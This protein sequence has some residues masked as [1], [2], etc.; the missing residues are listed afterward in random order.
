MKH[1]APFL[2]VTL[3]LF[4]CS[5]QDSPLQ[6]LDQADP[7]PDRAI[8]D[9]TRA[10]GDPNFVWG[11]PIGYPHPSAYEQSDLSRLPILAVEVSEWDGWDWQILHRF[12]SAGDELK[13]E[14]HELEHIKILDPDTHPRYGVVWFARDDVELG[15]LYRITVHVGAAKLGYADVPVVDGFDVWEVDSEEFYGINNG[16]IVPIE[17]LVL[18]G[19]F[20]R[21]GDG[22][23]D[24]YDNCPYTPNPEQ[25]DADTDGDRL[26]D[27]VE[28][29]TGYFDNELITGTDPNNPD[30]DGDRL[31]DGD[32]IL[33]TLEGL[34]LPGFGVSPLVPSILIEYDWFE[35]DGHSHRPTAAALAKVTASFAAQ[36]IEVI[37]DYGQGPAPFTGGN[38]I[39]DEDGNVNWDNPPLPPYLPDE[40]TLHTRDNRDRNRRYWIRYVMLPHTINEVPNLAGL[41]L[42]PG[43]KF[44]V[45]TSWWHG[46][47]QWVA[48]VIQHEL[49]HNLNLQHGGDTSTNNKPNYNSIMNYN[50]VWSGVDTDCTPVGNGVLDYS[51]GRYPTLNENNLNEWLGI[52]GGVPGW[53]WNDDG[54]AVDRSVRADINRPWTLAGPS[55]AGDG[56]F[57]VL[58]D[59]DDWSNLSY[60]GLPSTLPPLSSESGEIVTC[61]GPPDDL[62]GGDR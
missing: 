34:D 27:C 25:S 26:L 51:H 57:E 17:F 54:D 8:L 40:F 3:A 39:P 23:P 12:T 55:G 37:H 21:D 32:E 28:T 42:R 10:G 53:D 62:S 48:N 31:S 5:L 4:A 47:D 1:V 38:L 22:V 6:P 50:Y 52:C 20:D 18:T 2:M 41:A 24:A 33:G 16:W 60:H 15:K 45:A 46:N 29:G 9:G 43:S 61:P 59:Y 49:G 13:D 36:G 14:S 56:L 19:A 11:Q 44:I 7:S 35:H 30:T 58:Y